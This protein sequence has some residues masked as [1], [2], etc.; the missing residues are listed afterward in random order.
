MKDAEDSLCFSDPW[1]R[2]YPEQ[3]CRKHVVRGHGRKLRLAWSMRKSR[4][5]PAVRFPSRQAGAKAPAKVSPRIARFRTE[6]V[7]GC[8]TLLA[9]PRYRQP[10]A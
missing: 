1:V 3:G 8:D 9:P 7:E 4:Q 6:L 2:D 10:G 5:G